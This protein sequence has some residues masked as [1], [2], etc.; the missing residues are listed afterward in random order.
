VRVSLLVTGAQT[1]REKGWSNFRDDSGESMYW[2][3]LTQTERKRLNDAY[4]EQAAQLQLSG[5]EELPRDVKRKVRA[6]VLRMIR[7]ERKARSAK[8]LRTK[9]YRAAENTFT[10]QPARRR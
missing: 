9:V 3:K 2:V 8:A 4:V 10:W 7:A 1:D 5:R 6:D